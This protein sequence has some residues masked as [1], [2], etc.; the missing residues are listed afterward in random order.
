MRSVQLYL[1][2]MLAAL[3]ATADVY[4][5]VDREGRTQFGDQPPPGAGERVN[6]RAA[7]A[8]EPELAERRLK[9]QRLLDAF[10]EERRQQQAA[11]REMRAEQEQRRQYCRKARE[12]LGTIEASRQL[13]EEDENGARRYR[14]WEDKEK[15]QAL[16]KTRQAI[17]KYC[18]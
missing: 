2:L 10:E 18:D 8:P 9:R 4:R 5:W 15:Q 7:P 16:A 1:L 3:P 13:Y 6:I 17:S 14:R 12:Q 11:T